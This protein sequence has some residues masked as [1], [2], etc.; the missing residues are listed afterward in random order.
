MSHPEIVFKT[1]EDA[2]VDVPA[3]GAAS[4]AELPWWQWVQEHCDYREK[5][6]AEAIGEALGEFCAQAREYCDREVA[7]LKREQE[8][9]QRELR[10]L[11]EDIGLERGLKKLREEVKQARSEVPRVPEIVAQFERGHARLTRELAATQDRVNHLRTNQSIADYQLAELR[12][13]AEAR[14]TK[15]EMKIETSSSSFTMREPDPKA[16]KA[17]KDFAA[18]VISNETIWMFDFSR[19]SS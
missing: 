2:A 14:A 8:L 16:A 11:R 4:D 9:L 13:E 10:A 12:R 6:A 5:V 3:V 7:I 1:R 17:L 15:M 19:A 18:G